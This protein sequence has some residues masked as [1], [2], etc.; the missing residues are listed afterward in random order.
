MLIVEGI[1]RSRLP[2]RDHGLFNEDSGKYCSV[3]CFGD[4]LEPHKSTIQC[5]PGFVARVRHVLEDIR[6]NLTTYSRFIF[7][8]KNIEKV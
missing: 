7:L 4:K 1:L 8:Q 2:V 3:L 6:R 5:I